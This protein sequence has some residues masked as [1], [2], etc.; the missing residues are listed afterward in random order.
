VIGVKK[1]LV[2]SIRWRWFLAGKN[3]RTRIKTG[4]FFD[5]LKT[6]KA[7]HPVRVVVVN[8][9]VFIGHDGRRQRPA[10]KK[11]PALTLMCQWYDDLAIV[12]GLRHVLRMIPYPRDHR[13]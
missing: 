8:Q 2:N 6:G 9:S 11:L 4:Q 10:G 1:I 3:R 7:R 5:N 12:R 13:P